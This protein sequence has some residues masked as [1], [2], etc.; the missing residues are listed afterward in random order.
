MEQPART[1]TRPTLL[2]R[3]R[4]QPHDQ[5]A[6]DEFV[7]YYGPV[8]RGW[9]RHWRLQEADIDDVTQN[10][11]L[12]LAAKL[13]EFVYDPS[14][15]FRAWLKTL[16]HHAWQDFLHRYLAPVAATGDSHV[17]R[18]LDTTP[19]QDDLLARL[20]AAFDRE[21]AAIAMARVR[22]RVAGP[23]WDAFHLTAVEGLNASEAAAHLQIPVGRVYLARHR[24]Q[25]LL[26]E[27]LERLDEVETVTGPGQP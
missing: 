1:E 3:L 22:E 5:V 6:W 16:T 25:Q 18:V 2:A 24:V 8:I 19:A 10:V 21:L 14:K 4:Q 15:S 27:E 12:R 13:P 17:H 20:D 23:T 7:A 11:L 9:C 26:R